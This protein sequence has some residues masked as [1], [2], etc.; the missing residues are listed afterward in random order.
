M[1]RKG[2]KSVSKMIYICLRRKE[3]MS[4]V[5]QQK[6][7]SAFILNFRQGKHIIYFLYNLIKALLRCF[8]QNNSRKQGK[9]VD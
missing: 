1:E 4:C 8:Q 2:E 7:K 5:E 9:S 3:R 6:Q